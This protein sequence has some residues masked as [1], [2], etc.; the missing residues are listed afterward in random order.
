MF[1]AI[2]RSPIVR[3]IIQIVGCAVTNV[4][5]CAAISA[6]L[7]LAAGG[8]VVD[9][10]KAA[11]FAFAQVHIW[12][13]V[14]TAVNNIAGA[15]ISGAQLAGDAAYAAFTAVKA[16]IHGVVGGAIA[17]AQGGNFLQGFIGI[18]GAI[19]DVMWILRCA[20]AVL[21]VGTRCDWRYS[22]AVGSSLSV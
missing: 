16:G 21:A 3:A 2:L 14:G 6:S 7:A 8:S 22:R 19:A 13:Y 1:K 15:V 4:V 18:A 10:L 12:D 5:G 17:A 9:A 20:T 11:A